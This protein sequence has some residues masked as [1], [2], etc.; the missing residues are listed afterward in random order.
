MLVH[1]Y[2]FTADGSCSEH[3]KFICCLNI[4]SFY[5]SNPKYAWYQLGGREN[6][7]V[8]IYVKYIYTHLLQ[9]LIYESL[10]MIQNLSIDSKLL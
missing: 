5:Q 7:C 4:F 1:T 9:H 2:P 6:V 3:N 10:V 8:Y